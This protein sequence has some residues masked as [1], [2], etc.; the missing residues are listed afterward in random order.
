MAFEEA[1]NN[2]PD[3]CG[4]SK[5][6]RKKQ[7]PM[8]QS[9][10]TAEIWGKPVVSLLSDG[11][12]CFSQPRQWWLGL[13]PWSLR[14][15]IK[16]NVTQLWMYL[17]PSSQSTGQEL[18]AIGHLFVAHVLG[19]DMFILETRDYCQ[20][21]TCQLPGLGTILL[22]EETPGEA[23]HC[24]NGLVVSRAL[25]SLL[26]HPR[27]CLCSEE[28]TRMHFNSCALVV[29]RGVLWYSVILTIHEW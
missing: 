10:H 20:S 29:F 4:H 26:P 23:H 18:R 21:S 17:C 8:S 9:P 25:A 15:N 3:N 12:G 11:V 28:F 7:A 16:E 19:Q 27:H 6:T 5:A 13:I 2:F 14:T 1:E 22:P 24:Y